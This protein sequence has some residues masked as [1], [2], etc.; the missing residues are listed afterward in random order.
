LR[1][2]S[3]S[4]HDKSGKYFD[5][6]QVDAWKTIGN[7]EDNSN[8]RLLPETRTRVISFVYSIKKIKMISQLYYHAIKKQWCLY[9]ILPAKTR[10]RAIYGSLLHQM[11]T[12][13]MSE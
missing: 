9:L 11:I 2:V 4:L 12:W 10:K 5:S 7:F 13:I 3:R 8:H 1:L 6:Y